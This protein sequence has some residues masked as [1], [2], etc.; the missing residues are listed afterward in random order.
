MDQRPE[1]CDARKEGFLET[2]FEEGPP[3]GRTEERATQGLA[4]LSLTDEGDGRRERDRKEDEGDGAGIASVLNPETTASALETL[5]SCAATSKVMYGAA[6]VL[7]LAVYQ[8]VSLLIDVVRQHLLDS[9]HGP[10]EPEGT[11]EA[12]ITSLVGEL[13]EETLLTAKG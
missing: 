7:M 5:K 9:H 8:L 11:P 3:A 1:T 2:V 6:F 4:K 10:P 13:A 12:N